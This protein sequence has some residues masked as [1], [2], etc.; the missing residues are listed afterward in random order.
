MPEPWQELHALR[1]KP[2]VIDEFQSMSRDGLPF[3]PVALLCLPRALD[4]CG[5]FLIY[6]CDRIGQVKIMRIVIME[7]GQEFNSNGK[8]LVQ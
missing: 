4:F 2:M 5:L 1:A 3:A 8:F 6:A 7:W